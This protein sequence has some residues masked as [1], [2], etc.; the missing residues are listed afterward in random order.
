MKEIDLINSID[1][2]VKELE[3]ILQ[4]ETETA[5]LIKTCFV[6]NEVTDRWTISDSGLNYQIPTIFTKIH[7]RDLD[8][9]LYEIYLALKKDPLNK[10]IIESYS[11]LKNTFYIYITKYIQ[12]DLEE[13]K[14]HKIYLTHEMLVNISRFIYYHLLCLVFDAKNP[15]MTIKDLEQ[16]EYSFSLV[17]Y[18]TQDNSNYLLMTEFLC[19]KHDGWFKNS[20]FSIFI[21]KEDR[22]SLIKIKENLRISL[23]NRTLN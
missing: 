11:K 3:T 6:F 15:N 9:F 22:F 20:E 4:D 8:N 7:H 1:Q 12:L 16:Y 14:K 17:E 21:D 19:E 18:F 13:E 23:R 5:Y 10:K 2:L